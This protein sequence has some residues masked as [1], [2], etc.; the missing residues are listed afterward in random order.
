MRKLLFLMALAAATPEASAQD[1]SP[2]WVKQLLVQGQSGVMELVCDKKPAAT[3]SIRRPDAD[4]MEVPSEDMVHEV[5]ASP[6]AGLAPLKPAASAVPARVPG[7]RYRMAIWGDSHLAA[8]FF[9]EEL[10]KLLDVPADAVSNVLLPANMGRAGV[11]LPIRRS[12]VSSQ[13]KYEPGYLGG[14]KAVAPGPGLS[15]MSS[16]QPGATLAWDLRKDAQAPGYERVRV[17]YQQTDT[18][19]RVGVSVDGGAEQEVT[20]DGRP[21][22]AMLELLAERP[23]SQVKLRLIEGRLRFHGLELYSREAHAFEMDVFGYPGA[24][25]AGWKSADLAYLRSWFAQ[26]PYQLVVLEFGTNEG[27][28]KPFDIAT[29][30][31]TLAESVRNMR[32]VFPQAA[33]ILVA[34][35]DRGVLVP[36]SANIHKRRGASARRAQKAGRKPAT[37]RPGIDLLAYSKIHADIAR[38]QREVAA[39]AG[40][41]AWSM[42][43]AMGGPGTSYRWAQQSPALMAKDLIHFTAAGYRQLARDFFREMSWT[44]LPASTERPGVPASTLF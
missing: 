44:A 27:N 2:P 9:T 17:L 30:R 4:P 43:D 41:V 24:T 3:P 13:W 33:C 21:G 29:Y 14:D 32:S 22:P 28:A 35:G 8:G 7:E 20:L 16:D 31:T 23:L 5:P 1:Q 42:Q 15:N 34:P 6:D 38:V 40:C 26:R 19:L 12:C 37:A 36:R 25:V 10:A 18:P 39:D 11:R